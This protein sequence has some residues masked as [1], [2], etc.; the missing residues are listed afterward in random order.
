MNDRKDFAEIVDQFL[1]KWCEDG[2]NL[3]VTELALFE[4]FRVFWAE[5]TQKWIHEA[6]FDEFHT[7]IKR[8]GY[9]F[10]RNPRRVW[11]GLKLRKKPK[12]E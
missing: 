1:E 6:S 12:G 5:A 8:R 3:H 10:V 7:E 9:R 11:Y 4:K 2:A